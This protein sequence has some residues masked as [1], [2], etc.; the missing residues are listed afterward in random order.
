M[1]P[2]F[3]ETLSR[4]VFL[5]FFPFPP[6]LP[7]SGDAGPPML[8][9]GEQEVGLTFCWLAGAFE[10]ARSQQESPSVKNPSGF[11]LVAPALLSLIF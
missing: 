6:Q 5:F 2:I 1:A 10:A 7:L 3:P 9:E 11:L 4:L 8:E